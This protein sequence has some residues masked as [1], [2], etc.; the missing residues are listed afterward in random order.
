[1]K[2]RLLITLAGLLALALITTNALAV[3][4][5]G[6]KGG[7]A[8][9]AAGITTALQGCHL[10]GVTTGSSRQAA[11]RVSTATQAAQYGC[12]WCFSDADGDGI[13]DQWTVSHSAA[14]SAAPASCSP[15]FTDANGDGIC[16]Y[17][18]G[19]GT[20]PQDGTGRQLGHHRGN[21]C[22]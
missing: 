8:V 20:R 13:C 3:V 10:N 18:A 4:P 21:H 19:T 12:G 22:R 6:Q 15:H 7:K 16:D 17:H 5:I 1:M 14:V 2:K 11:N 9:H